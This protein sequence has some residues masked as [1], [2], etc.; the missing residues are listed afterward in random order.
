M[1]IHPRG[2]KGHPWL[3]LVLGAAAGINL[4]CSDDSEGPTQPTCAD[5]TAVLA[6]PHPA[7]QE[8]NVA[9]T[10]PAGDR[11]AELLRS[12]RPAWAE[13]LALVDGWP[14]RPTILLP[15]DGSAAAAEPTAI[16]LY[17]ATEA[18]GALEEQD[19]VFTVSLEDGGGTLKVQPVDPLPPG[20]TEVVV[21]VSAAATDGARPLPVCGAGGQPHPAYADAQSR[22]P[23]SADAA[24][25]LP[26]SLAPTA[27][28]LGALYATLRSAPQ[29]EVVSVEG[30]ALDSFAEHVPP[31]EV[32]ASMAPTVAKGILSLPAYQGADGIMQA[33]TDGALTPVS[34]TEPGFIVALPADGQAPFPF[35]LYQHG[36]TQQK[37]NILPIAGPLTSAGFALV[38][39]DLP[40]HG[41]RAAPGGGSDLDI[42]NFDSP[43]ETRDNLRQASADHLAVLTGIDALNAAL[44][45]IFGQ[46]ASLDPNRAHYMGL[47]LGGVTGT[48]T[49]A[50]APDLQAASLFVG[51]G[52]YPEILSSGLFSIY[53]VDLL[54]HEGAERV[55]LLGLVEA[56]LDGGDPLAYANAEDRSAP[57]R[58]VVFFEA[59]DDPV[60]ANQATDQWARAFGAHL[61]EPSH[62]PVDHA[63]TQSLPA[64]DNFSWPGGSETATRLLI[65]APMNE[66]G[67]GERHGGL[68]RQ[69]YSQ[70]LVTHC[71]DSL[72]TTGT[73]EVID[74]GFAD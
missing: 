52:G 28:Q 67:V 42:L 41:D 24:L 38:A 73:C 74:T 12:V 1:R 34:R 66:I 72:G 18:G 33:T 56:L 29:L 37:E 61:A 43:L 15:L 63:P 30:R 14:Q 44:E 51:G 19:V 25:A 4:G 11:A 20:L 46:P 31:P 70:E 32:A 26:F 50:S 23:A 7:W 9:L 71:F 39:I 68:I 55:A 47:S 2:P 53:V 59:I 65:Q 6:L 64:A 27:A 48:F 35:V 54:A 60:I 36:G 57:P 40:Y 62:H 8:T 45:A 16:R 58:P 21:A 10:V 5:P 22:L 3:G 49:F 13:Q 69:P 17:G